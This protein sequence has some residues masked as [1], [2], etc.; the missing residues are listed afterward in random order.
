MGRPDP[1]EVIEF[2]EFALKKVYPARGKKT[3][4]KL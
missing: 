2:V 1:K 4:F 3:A